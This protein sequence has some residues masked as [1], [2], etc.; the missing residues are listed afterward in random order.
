LPPFKP[1]VEA[2]LT[3]ALDHLRQ[4]RARSEELAAEVDG[5]DPVPG[6]GAGFRRG[7][8][9]IQDAGV[10]HQHVDAAETLE[11]GLRHRR[12]RGLV[13]DVGGE[14]QR[15]SPSRLDRRRGLLG[16]LDVDRH[17]PGALGGEALGAR[18]ADPRAGAGHQR[19]LP[20][21]PLAGHHPLP[22]A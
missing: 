14:R 10:V 2:T 8:V 4:E 3:I 1:A 5:E 22:S 16:A 13:A 7:L 20:L 12:H 9:G 6:L 21:Q 18:P 19:H 11:R 15:L 17:D